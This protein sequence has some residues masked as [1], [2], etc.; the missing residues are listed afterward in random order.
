M[1]VLTPPRSNERDSVTI[2][3]LL[4]TVYPEL[5]RLARALMRRERSDHTL[6]PT[7]VV[8]EAL[9]KLMGLHQL[10]IVSVDHFYSLMVG[11]MRRTLTSYARRR[12]A[13]K[14]FAGPADSAETVPAASI[15]IEALVLIDEVLD[16]LAAIDTRAYRIV[17]LRFYGGLSTSEIAAVL[18][19]SQTAVER[20]WRFARPWLFGE[21]S[22]R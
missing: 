15:N 12:L 5:R 14:R 21:I 3:R 18:G 6:Q 1:A 10:R 17:C 11:E 19:V 4:D 9:L 22:K 20:D 16:R 8:H 7:A 2:Q 13:H